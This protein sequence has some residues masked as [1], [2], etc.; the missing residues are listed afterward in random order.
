MLGAALTIGVAPPLP[1]QSTTT[2]EYRAE[3]G[4]AVQK[5]IIGSGVVEKRY[6]SASDDQQHIQHF[7]SANCFRDHLTRGGREEGSCGRACESDVVRLGKLLRHRRVV[8]R[9]A[10]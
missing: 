7:L 1:G 3:Q 5:R 2:P 4:L 10:D 6:A 8:R 9:S